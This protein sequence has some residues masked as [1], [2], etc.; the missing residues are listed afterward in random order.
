M[1]SQ[2]LELSFKEKCFGELIYISRKV[3]SLFVKKAEETEKKIEFIEPPLSE[4][5]I[6]KRGKSI[7]ES[8][9]T[10]AQ[11]SYAL[12][13]IDLIR[14]VNKEAFDSLQF[15]IKMKMEELGFEEKII[16]KNEKS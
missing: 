1:E 16:L 7:V 9:K 8:C 10:A 5:D 11:F 14:N 6:F 3:K 4:V 13:Y 15:L 12:E 2:Y